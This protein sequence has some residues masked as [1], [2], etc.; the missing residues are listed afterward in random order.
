M[1][2]LRERLAQEKREAKEAQGGKT[3]RAAAGYDKRK[4]ILLYFQEDG[5]PDV[6]KLS[7]RQREML[8][9][10]RGT[11]GEAAA[12]DPAGPP[13]A[14]PFTPQIAGVM[15]GV[16]ISIE[17]AI[18]APRMD[19]DASRVQAALTPIPPIADAIQET[20]TRVMNKYAGTLGPYTDEIALCGLIVVWQSSAFSEIRRMKAAA[21]PAP[22]PRP[23]PV[24]I[25]ASVEPKPVIVAP[26]GAG[27]G[28]GPGAAVIDKP[29]RMPPPPAAKVV[30]GAPEPAAET[31][32]DASGNPFLDPSEPMG[33]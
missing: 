2:R 29:F 21:A 31:A 27:P 33:V 24:D 17:S 7:E 6:S 11:D 18:V 10:L 8:G 12:G 5:S 20:A 28:G 32:A 25:H 30:N 23:L 16:L 9:M 22:E 3:G 19:L 1:A 15:L 14:P 13:P 26:A 4:R